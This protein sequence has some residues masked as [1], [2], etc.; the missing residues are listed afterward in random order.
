MA[1]QPTS[2]T[3]T[4]LEWTMLVTLSLFWG[5]SFFFTGIAIKELPAL[6]ITLLR[7][8]LAALILHAVL[9]LRGQRMPG[10]RKV[11]GAFFTMGLINSAIPICLIA[12]G[13]AQIASGLASILAATSPLFGVVIA[14]GFTPD[15]RMSSN[16]I[17]GVVIGFSGVVAMVGPTALGGLGADVAAELAVLAAA[18]F[19]AT[20]SV[21]GRRFRTMN[22]TPLVTA[23]GQVTAS[24]VMLLPVALL[25][26]RPWLLGFPSERVLA[27]VLGLAIL[28]TVLGYL[29]Y[30]RI[31]STAGATNILLVAFLV[32]VS[33]VMLGSL[34]L[35]ER[36]DPR[37]FLGMALIGVGLASMD[38][39]LLRWLR[40]PK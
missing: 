16:R 29:L 23:T 24:T 39:R 6:M 8:S 10:G 2:R 40:R 34:V 28:S 11:W 25:V 33:A 32:P 36:L 27:A 18:V 37:H 20:A 31:L 15:E 30:F 7:I 12:W 4:P 38:G 9:L 35:G 13:Q 17:A 14:H 19:S 22:L 26:D 5:G 1:S 21:F 3:M